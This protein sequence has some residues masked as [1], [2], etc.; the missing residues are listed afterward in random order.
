MTTV[1]CDGKTM[2][3]DTLASDVWGMREKTKDKILRGKD[4]LIGCSGDSGQILRWWKT[5]QHLCFEELL[6]AGYAPY[7]KDNDPGL[8]L[9]S[10]GSIYRHTAGTFTR[11]S[12][13]F[14]AVGSGR[15]YALAAMYLG[16]S[17]SEAVALAREFDLHTGG[18]IITYD[19]LDR[20]VI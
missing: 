3:A 14:H 13:P 5:V 9:A 1:A 6:A 8:V 7:E 11:V 15:D 18:E 16:K 12:R 17:A 19:T 20:R 10:A 2:A 4:F